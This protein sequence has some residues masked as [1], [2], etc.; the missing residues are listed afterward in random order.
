MTSVEAHPT[1]WS[2][3]QGAARGRARLSNAAQGGDHRLQS[4]DSSHGC[5]YL[6]RPGCVGLH[7]DG[8]HSLDVLP[9]HEQGGG[10]WAGW[11]LGEVTSVE[12]PHGTPALNLLSYIY[13]SD[14]LRRWKESKTQKL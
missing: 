13:Y 14:K 4:I 11:G 2:T 12:R 9:V 6:I 1:S 8:A 5:I 3:H 7:D 10:Y